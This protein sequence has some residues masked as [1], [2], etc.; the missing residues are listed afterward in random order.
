MVVQTRRKLTVT[1]EEA[2]RPS[3]LAR[4]NRML[5]YWKVQESAQIRHHGG[6]V[7][8]CLERLDQYVYCSS[9]LQPVRYSP[10]W[11]SRT[12]D[13]APLVTTSAHRW[14]AC[15][16]RKNVRCMSRETQCVLY[17]TKRRGIVA[18]EST[19]LGWKYTGDQFAV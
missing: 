13:W 8:R 1:R 9:E 19:D 14:D 6:L 11:Q 4:M 2:F 5:G 3:S 17:D 7:A 12:G 10:H 18:L 16:R 15:C